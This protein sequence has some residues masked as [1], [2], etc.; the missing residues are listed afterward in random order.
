MKELDFINIIKTQTS[1]NYIGDDCAFLKEFN[2]VVTQDNFVEDVHFKREWMS[3]YQIGY[4]SATVNISDVLAS[5]AEP[6]FLTV[7]LS[8]PASV[9]DNFVKEFYRGVK[10]A[11][12]NVEVIGGDITGADKIF[13]SI[14]AF[15]DTR[16]RNISSRKYAKSG[17]VVVV[18]GECGSSSFG[19]D[20]LW[21]NLLGKEKKEFQN[22]IKKHREPVLDWDF[23]KQVGKNIVENYAM[24]DTS[25]GLADAIFKIAD[26]SNVTIELDY[27]KI[28][29]NSCVQ[30]EKY[31]LFGGE[32]Y[33]LV[34]VFDKKFLKYLDKYNVIGRV[35]NRIDDVKLIVNNKTYSRYED[36]YVYE[37][38]KNT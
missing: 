25:D 33:R 5:G 19:L 37:H 27:D 36:L 11:A 35:N 12:P 6:K 32:D 7:G 29:H 18:S 3:A 21:G 1:S 22:L 38:F 24:M 4:K 10:N 8:M 15:G 17:D 16:G 34:A 2:L 31:I 26:L 23:S 13:V 14:T 9:D 20:L 28:P 30:E